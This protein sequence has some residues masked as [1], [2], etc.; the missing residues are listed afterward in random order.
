MEAAAVNEGVRVDHFSREYK[1]AAAAAAAELHSG[2]EFGSIREQC[3]GCV[4][5]A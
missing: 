1:T 2:Q 3:V 5:S 4:C